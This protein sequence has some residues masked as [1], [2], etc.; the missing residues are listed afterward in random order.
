[1]NVSVEVY[2]ASMH[3]RI[4]ALAQLCVSLLVTHP[5]GRAILL[6][7]KFA[8]TVKAGL[9]DAKND[10]QRAYFDGMAE[11]VGHMESGLKTAAQAV[12]MR[13]L[14]PEGGH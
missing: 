11:I 4:D 12:Q 9:R 3:G 14:K 5:D 2:M 1:M 8:E 13:E 7:T 6:A 10:Q